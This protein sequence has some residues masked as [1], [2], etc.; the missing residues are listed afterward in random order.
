MDAAEGREGL[1][2]LE[3]RQGE[4]DDAVVKFDRLVDDALDWVCK[5]V[6]A[7]SLLESVCEEACCNCW[8][9][10][11]DLSM[12]FGIFGRVVRGRPVRLSRLSTGPETG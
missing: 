12:R 9:V 11:S 2:W 3:A 7:G 8:G 1:S 4:E 10:G 5:E 6:N